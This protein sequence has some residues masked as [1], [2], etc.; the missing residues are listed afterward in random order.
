MNKKVK[1]IRRFHQVYKT[2]SFSELMMK[3]DDEF[4]E[5]VVDM[6][7]MGNVLKESKFDNSGELEERNDYCYTESGK[8]LEHELYYALDDVTE[9]RLFKRNDKGLLLQEVK[10]YGE[11]E[12]EKIEYT[13]DAADRV[14]SLIRYD[15]EGD[16]DF[17][18]EFN[19]DEKG[20]LLARHKFSADGRL[21]EELTAQRGESLLVEEKSYDDSGAL[22]STTITQFDSNG[23]ELSSRQTNSQGKLIAAINTTYDERGNVVERAYKDFYSKTIRY[24]YDE[25]NRMTTQ[26][27][28]DS[29]GLLLRKNIYEYDD[30]GQLVN[31]QVFE[32]DASRGGRDKHYGMRFEYDYFS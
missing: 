29:T 13:Y 30:V 31:E 8:L 11:D 18:E 27:L 23:K 19:Y 22:E 10:V 9:K 28:F 7:A 26:E 6:D 17:R 2:L 14:V 4:L 20:E 25:E 1:T 32:I 24:A 3:A 16:Q 5:L 21:L 15:E 12:G